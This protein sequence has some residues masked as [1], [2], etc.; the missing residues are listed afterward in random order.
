MTGSAP[1]ANQILAATADN[2][3]L[4]AVSGGGTFKL[5]PA[6]KQA[7]QAA[8]LAGSAL[9]VV[10]MAA[11]TSMDSTFMGAIAA[12][13]FALRKSDTRLALINLSA[14]ASALLQGLGVDRILKIYPAETLPAKLGDLSMLEQNL[15]PVDTGPVRDHELAALMYDAHETLTRVDPQNLQRFKDVLAYLREDL[16]R[17]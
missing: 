7:V 2:C 4:V 8:T 10:D 16:K 15:R 5:A 14:H 6:F 17:F 11:C 13:G 3:T 1:V 9:I 12:L